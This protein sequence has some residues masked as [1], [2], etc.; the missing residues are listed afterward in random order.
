MNFAL[1]NFLL[2][3]A[4]LLQ[5]FKHMLR[6][7]KY[8]HLPLSVVKVQASMAYST[9]RRSSKYFSFSVLSSFTL[10]WP[11]QKNHR[12]SN[13]LNSSVLSN[14]KPLEPSHILPLDQ[15]RSLPRP[16]RHCFLGQPAKLHPFHVS[17]PLPPVF[18][19]ALYK[20]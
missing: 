1:T 8:L 11:I 12:S 17:S 4:N 5:S 14:F 15:I 20:F 16:V 6:T 7:L 13:C 2:K 3:Y 10:L 19:S 18:L 9:S